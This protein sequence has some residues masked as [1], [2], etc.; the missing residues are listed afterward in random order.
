MGKLTTLPTS[1]IHKNEVALRSVD[2]ESEEFL[3]I[4]DS[5]RTRGFLGVILVREKKDPETSQKFYEL[6]DGLQRFTAAC[7][8]GLEEIPVDITKADDAEVLRS[9]IC[10]NIHRVVTK[11]IEYSK[12][13]IQILNLDSTLTLSTLAADLGKSTQWVEQRLSLTKITNE[14]IQAAV[15]EGEIPLS[16]AYIL[17]KLPETEQVELMDRAITEQPAEFVP[18]AQARKKELAAASRKGKAAAPAEF[19]P[20]Q[21]LRKLK[22]IK[23]EL[24]ALENAQSICSNA[25]EQSGFRKAIEWVLCVDSDTIKVLKSEHD[26]RQAEKTEKANKRK[27]ERVERKKAAAKKAAEEA[28]EAA[29]A[30][31][32]E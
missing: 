25:D 15:N 17:A 23:L 4:V 16:N 27:L 26:A 20:V 6:I 31:M 3:G 29:K 5:I 22:E 12:Q 19:L 30:A 2:M 10:M 21:H 14:R 8:A 32:A 7:E 9:Q 11:P 28:E 13:L 1:A 18:M 24:G